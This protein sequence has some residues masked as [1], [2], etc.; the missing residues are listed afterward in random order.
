M[1]IIEVLRKHVQV[2]FQQLQKRIQMKDITVLQ[3]L[4]INLKMFKLLQVYWLMVAPVIFIPAPN[5]NLHV[6]PQKLKQIFTLPQQKLGAEPI[7]I[8][9]NCPKTNNFNTKFRKADGRKL[10][11]QHKRN[12][13]EERVDA[14]L[15]VIGSFF[16]SMVRRT[17]IEMKRSGIEIY[18]CAYVIK[19]IEPLILQRN[20]GFSAWMDKKRWK[21]LLRSIYR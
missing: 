4:R 3:R 10:S 13:Y 15:L 21:N 19:I 6:E 1:K 17:D 9:I 12:R 16:V 20:Q 5:P 8:S 14:S 2:V 7:C 18:A 11:V